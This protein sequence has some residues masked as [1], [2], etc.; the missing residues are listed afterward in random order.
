MSRK[1]VVLTGAGRDRVGIVAELTQ[2]LY[3]TGCNLLDSSCTLLSGQF[4]I[5]L[6]AELGQGHSVE[7]LKRDLLRVEEQLGMHIHVRELSADELQEEPEEPNV[8][9]VSVYGA[10]KA[11]IVARVTRS[12]ADLGINITDV[13]T[14]RTGGGQKLFVMILEV[15]APS[16]ISRDHLQ[17]S[18][19]SL[20]ASLAV[21]ISIQALDVVEL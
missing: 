20:A 7:G 2:L 16:N 9:I 8:F 18:L 6:M 5:I 21:D 10:D 12:L 14:K 15:S 3:E 13:Q 11:G 19:K 17:N 4:A 1:T